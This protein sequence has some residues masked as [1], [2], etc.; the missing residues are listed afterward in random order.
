MRAAPSKLQETA[1]LVIHPIQELLGHKNFVQFFSRLLIAVFVFGVA[2]TLLDSY[3]SAS[4]GVGL[5]EER[6]QPFRVSEINL[7]I[8]SMYTHVFFLVIL[9]M[10]AKPKLYALSQVKTSRHW[11]GYGLFAAVSFAFY[12]LI[13]SFVIFNPAQALEVQPAIFFMK[14]LTLFLTVIFLIL[15]LLDR[16]TIIKGIK[17]FWKEALIALI[18]I[19]IFNKAALTLLYSYELF[20][21][22]WVFFAQITTV[23]TAFLL[24]LVVPGVSHSFESVFRPML[25]TPTF[26]AVI[27]RSCSG[28]V[29]LSLFALLFGLILIMDWHKINKQRAAVA[30]V[31]G[32]AGIV[33]VNI[34]RITSL[35]LVGIF[36]SRQF[37]LGMFHTNIGLILFLVY[38]MIFEF[39]T[40]AWMR[41]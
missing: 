6:I 9:Y 36:V 15:A 27:A 41:K 39:Y 4:V 12:A 23:G 30:F 16:E 35:F 13:K 11:W 14:Y 31:I 22:E 33:G 19:Q 25:M 34:I 28:I 40:Y 8:G 2:L 20:Q 17:R 10:I 24:S 7:L 3:L 5:F 32:L 29:G 21:N 1:S 18:F 26:T 38:F 37:A